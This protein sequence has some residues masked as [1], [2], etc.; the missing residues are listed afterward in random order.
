MEQTTI[1]VTQKWW[2]WV[3]ILAGGGVI[4]WLLL[5]KKPAQEAPKKWTYQD[6]VTGQVLSVTFAPKAITDAL[7]NAIYDPS[8]W[9][10][11]LA[12]SGLYSLYGRDTAIFDKL[13]S[14]GDGEFVAVATDWNNR[15]QKEDNETLRVAIYGEYGLGKVGTDLEARFIKLNLI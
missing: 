10:W 5:R 1:K 7:H 2:F 8:V 12:T 13:L 4:A 15:Y 3:I 14:L 6:P 9:G 11:N